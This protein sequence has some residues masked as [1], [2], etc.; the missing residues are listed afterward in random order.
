MEFGVT[1][2]TSDGTASLDIEGPLDAPKITITSDPTRPSG[3]ALAMLVFGNQYSE[4]SPLKI[5]QL[6]ASAAQ[7]S[8]AGGGTNSIRE[9][10]GV[11]D[12]DLST[13][14]DGNAQ[15]GVGT[16]LADGVYTDVSVNTKGDT[17][18]NLNLDVTDS[19][20]LKGT[21]DSTGETGLGVFFERDY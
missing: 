12:L 6:A 18:V 3:E 19:L 15:V 10:L 17:E 8:G 14:D 13:D 20:T 5:A 4:L 16:Y 1:S 2:S 11:D 7:L 21:V 9:G